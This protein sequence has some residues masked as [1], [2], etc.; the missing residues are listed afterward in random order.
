[1]TSDLDKLYRIGLLARVNGSLISSQTAATL[2]PDLRAAAEAHTLAI[3][4]AG[5]VASVHIHDNRSRFRGR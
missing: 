1:M 4:D 2:P 3:D 5:R